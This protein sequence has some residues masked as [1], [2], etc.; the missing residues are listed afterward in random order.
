MFGMGSSIDVD[1]CAEIR[2]APKAVL[3]G[4]SSQYIFMPFFAWALAMALGLSDTESMALLLVGMCPGGVTSTLFTYISKANVTM[5]LV[6]T[7]CSTFVALFMIPLLIFVYVRPPLI[8]SDNEN[9]KISYVAIIFTLLIATI[10]AVIGWYLRR[11]APALGAQAEK[12]A[13]AFG[14]ACI[15]ILVILTFAWP[16]PGSWGTTWKCIACIVLMCPCGFVFGY[17]FTTLLGMDVVTARTV[18]METGIQQVGIA[19]AIMLNSFKDEQLERSISVIIV[20]GVATVLFG[21]VWA[22]VLRACPLVMTHPAEKE[23]PKTTVEEFGVVQEL[24]YN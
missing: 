18:S 5:S 11:K 1:L 16:A 4:I 14:S 17:G 2:K 15:L 13:T 10:P 20:M 22:S 9:T 23:P 12:W 24:S 6:M 19:L 7:T 21:A 3:C 8:S